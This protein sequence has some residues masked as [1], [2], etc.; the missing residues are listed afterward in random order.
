[1][2]SLTVMC[3]LICLIMITSA[4]SFKPGALLKKPE[5]ITKTPEFNSNF[6]I[7]VYIISDIGKAIARCYDCG[8]AAYHDSA[9]I[10][11]N[12][13]EIWATWKLY[14]GCNGQVAIQSADTGKYL[15]RCYNCWNSATY[16]DFAFVHATDPNESWAHW[17]MINN[18]DGTYSFQSDTGKYLARCS[19]CVIGGFKSDYAFV[20]ASSNSE[21]SARFSLQLA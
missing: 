8:P 2:R 4:L 16:L 21:S 14:P 17:I 11:G 1:M 15:A 18:D 12:I 20:Y 7:K 9:A 5:E 13:G 3:F 10:H 19:N 6:W